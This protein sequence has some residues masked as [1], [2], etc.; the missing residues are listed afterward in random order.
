MG[1]STWRFLLLPL[2]LINGISLTRVDGHCVGARARTGGMMAIWRMHHNG[3]DVM[4]IG[5]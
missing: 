2:K 4:A 5:P 3:H 1:A